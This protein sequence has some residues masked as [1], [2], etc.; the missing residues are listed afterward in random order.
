MDISSGYKILMMVYIMVYD[1]NYYILLIVRAIR[2]VNSVIR[3]TSYILT[4]Y[5]NRA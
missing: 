1:Y 5:S 3:S 4:E 2:N